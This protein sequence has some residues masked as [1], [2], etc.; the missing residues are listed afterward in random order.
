MEN[1]SKAL[2][3]A[4]E[5]LIGMV[6]LSLMVYLF[7]TFGSDSAKIGKQ[8][9]ENRLA[10]FNSQY[11]KYVDKDDVTIYDIV[12]V[13]NLAKENNKYYELEESTEGNYYISIKKDGVSME[14]KTQEGLTKDIKNEELE[15]SGLPKYKC[16]VTYSNTT[17]R[18]KTVT[19]TKIH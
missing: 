10:E 11:N 4:A 3:L 1:A 13:A 15:N 8:I 17:A 7:V 18:V 12:T 19:F 9:E 16:L 2:L 14:T 6:V 5:V